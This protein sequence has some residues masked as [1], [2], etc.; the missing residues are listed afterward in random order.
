MSVKGITFVV[1]SA[2]ALSVAATPAWARPREV[3]VTGTSSEIVA[4]QVHFLDLNLASADGVNRLANRVH[5]AVN[6]LCLDAVGGR[7]G[8]TRAITGCQSQSWEGA[9]PQIERAVERAREIVAN[10]WSA[11]APVAITISVQ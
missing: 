8:Y 4:R 1:M 5:A 7:L 9:Q 11:I 6:S 3:V 2:A 10:G